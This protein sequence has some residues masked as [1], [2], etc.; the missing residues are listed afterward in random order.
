MDSA[1]SECAGAC[2]RPPGQWATWPSSGV[3]LSPYV[4]D[5]WVPW[6][7]PRARKP[8][9]FKVLVPEWGDRGGDNPASFLPNHTHRATSHL[10]GC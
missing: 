1:A 3:L 5:L 4:M 8:L 10:L 2:P 9:A 7:Q 6:H